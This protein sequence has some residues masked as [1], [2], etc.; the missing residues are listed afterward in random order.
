MSKNNTIL[1]FR[2]L[3]GLINGLID[4]KRHG[5]KEVEKIGENN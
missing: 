1:N 3:F 2:F 5:W 4:D